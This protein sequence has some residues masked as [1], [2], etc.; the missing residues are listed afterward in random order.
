MPCPF[1]SALGVPG[2]GFHKQR[3]GDF[4]LNDILGTMTLAYTTSA[5]TQTDY[6]KNLLLWFAAGEAAHYAFGVKT[7]VL[8]KLNIDPSCSETS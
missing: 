1:A 8:E 6:S 2:E 5:V 3:I 7:A 4:A